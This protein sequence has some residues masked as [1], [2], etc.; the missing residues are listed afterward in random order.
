[1][2]KY[3]EILGNE[4]RRYVKRCSKMGESMQISELWIFMTNFA[5]F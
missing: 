4:H 5:D 3:V 2:I 1:M